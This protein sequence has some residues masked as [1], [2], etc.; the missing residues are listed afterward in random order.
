MLLAVIEQSPRGVA[1]TSRYIHIMP[2]MSS[3]LEQWKE[4]QVKAASSAQPLVFR[5]RISVTSS[6]LCPAQT[7]ACIL[8]SPTIAAGIRLT[9]ILQSLCTS[10]SPSFFTS[11]TACCPSL[12]SINLHLQHQHLFAIPTPLSCQDVLVLC[13]RSRTQ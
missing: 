12:I 13:D 9:S 4:S 7:G 3:I 10:Y 5:T 2:S 1:Y 11:T 8:V 6:A